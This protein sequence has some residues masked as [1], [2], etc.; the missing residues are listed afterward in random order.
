L[1]SGKGAHAGP[2]G[3]D[4]LRERVARGDFDLVA[5]GRALLTDPEWANKVRENRLDD[6]RGFELAALGSLVVDDPALALNP[7]QGIRA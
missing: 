4:E 7:A 1:L 3:L 5:V 2:A 6:L